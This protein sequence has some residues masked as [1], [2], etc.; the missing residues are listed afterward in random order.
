MALFFLW[1]AARIDQVLLL[2]K[3]RARLH[4]VQHD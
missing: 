4:C 3:K 1:V 2:E